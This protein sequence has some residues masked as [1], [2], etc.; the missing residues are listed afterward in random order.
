VNGGAKT[1]H[2]AEQKSAS[3]GMTVALANVLLV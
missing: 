1:D 2:W 3:L